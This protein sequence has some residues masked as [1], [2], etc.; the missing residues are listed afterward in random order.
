MIYEFVPPDDDRD[1]VLQAWLT[2][3]VVKAG[4]GVEGVKS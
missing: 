4:I 3:E 1:D 2:R